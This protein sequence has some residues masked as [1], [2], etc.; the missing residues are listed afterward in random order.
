MSLI[1]TSNKNQTVKKHFNIVSN[2][3][4]TDSKVAV[5]AII[6]KILYEPSL[7]FQNS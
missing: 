3:N 5:E 6:L 2:I 7:C 1:Q 4:L